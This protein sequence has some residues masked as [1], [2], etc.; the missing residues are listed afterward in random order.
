MR[1]PFGDLRRQYLDMRERIDAAVGDVLSRGWFILGRE[2]ESFEREFA[3]YLGARHAVGVGSGTEALHLALVAAGVRPGDEVIAPANTCIPTVSAVS[4]AGAT[5]VLVDVD[6]ASFNLDPGKLEAALSPR[7]AAILPVH[8]YGQAADLGPILEIGRGSRIPVIE[9]VAQGHGATYG[10]GKLGTS[11]V[12]GCFSFYPSK[13]LG[14]YGD[15][16]AV[17]TNDDELALKLRRLRNYGEERRYHHTSKGFNSRLDELQAAILRAKLP[18]LDRWNARRREI[19]AI[20]DR[21]I[22]HPGIVKP[23]E[24]QYG[25]HVYHLYVVRCAERDRLQEHLA[26]A[27]V[28]TLIHYP[29]PVHLQQAYAD[30]G[31]KPGDYPVAEACASEALSLPIFPELTE[32]EVRYVAECINAFG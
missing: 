19:A 22:R 18:E 8:L 3:D 10:E 7:T 15:A 16:G 13:N 30:L 12:M 29:V 4:L 26:R 21:E 17:V 2:V 9:D 28:A 23:V 5:P 20:Y 1:V 27:G 31:K 11:G 32:E 24:L 25:V 6:P 14:A